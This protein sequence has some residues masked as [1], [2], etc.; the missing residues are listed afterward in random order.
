[1]LTRDGDT[2]PSMAERK[3][4]WKDAGVDLAISVHNNWTSDPFSAPG[5]SAYYKH[6]FD[7]P[8]AQALLGRMLETGLNL[9]GLT[10]NFNFSLNGPTDYPNALIEAMF[11]NSLQE[12]ELLASPEFRQKVAEKIFA[13]LQDYLKAAK[14]ARSQK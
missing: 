4:I 1:V 12:E 14:A 11:M 5:T 10:G 9:Y 7:R 8:L 2:G 13:G 3:R 6:L